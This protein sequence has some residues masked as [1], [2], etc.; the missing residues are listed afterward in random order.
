MR[1]HVAIIALCVTGCASPLHQG[2]APQP[3]ETDRRVWS[4]SVATY[5]DTDG[6]GIIDRWKRGASIYYDD[7]GD[8]VIGSMV[9]D[10]H[11]FDGIGPIFDT[12]DDGFF[13]SS[14]VHGELEEM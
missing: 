1:I 6:D 11:E 9:E 14:Y 10:M 4:N 7:D 13:D 8:G 3:D 5:T 2:Y 12:D